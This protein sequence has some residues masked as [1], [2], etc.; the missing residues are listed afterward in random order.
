MDLEEVASR[1]SAAV[2]LAGL[3]YDLADLEEAVASYTALAAEKLR[4]QDSL[5][6]A[7]QVMIKTNAL[8]PEVTQY[9]KAVTI[10]AY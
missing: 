10:R 7:V 2:P 1:S 3:I 5:T 8:K 4:H 9:Q 6:S